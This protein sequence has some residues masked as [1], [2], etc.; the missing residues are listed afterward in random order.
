M[1]GQ[2]DAQFDMFRDFL[3]YMERQRARSSVTSTAV[4]SSAPVQSSQRL[5]Y[6]SAPSDLPLS[7]VINPPGPFSLP[8][9]VSGSRGV[10]QQGRPLF[11]STP[12]LDYSARLRRATCTSRPS[13]EG[14]R[15]WG[16]PSWGSFGEGAP[17]AVG[18][19]DIPR[20]LSW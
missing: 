17:T 2:I 13:H 19:Q 12:P 18:D 4:S 8:A 6:T 16:A 10:Q 1:E 3:S 9:P 14:D 11:R 5:I 15:S 20:P 7:A